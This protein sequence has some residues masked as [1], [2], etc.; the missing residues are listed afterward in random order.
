MQDKLRGRFEA[1]L[2]QI[3]S[4]LD[5]KGGT[6]TLEK[7]WERIGR[8]KEKYRTVSSRYQIKVEQQQGKVTSLHWSLKPDPAKEDKSRG[9]YFVRTSYSQ[10]NADQLWQAY[11]TIRQLE[12][13][14]RCL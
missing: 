14:F 4:A 13:T 11:N 10:A 3:R 7:V 5:K 8:A 1:Q 9:V 6:K 2:Q 12:A